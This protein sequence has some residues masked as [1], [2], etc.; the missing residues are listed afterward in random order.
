MTT[1]SSNNSNCRDIVCIAFEKLFITFRFG[2]E[3]ID[4]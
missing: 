4:F 2:L 1:I 3:M